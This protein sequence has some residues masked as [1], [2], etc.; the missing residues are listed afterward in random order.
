MSFARIAGTGSYLPEG[1]LTNADLERMVDTSDEWI[2][3]RTGI[4]IRHMAAPG[5]VTSDLALHASR[6]ALEAA[7]LTAAELDL[8]LVATTTPDQIFPSTACLLQ[9][10]LEVGGCPAFDVQAVCSGF[11]YALA[12]A[13]QF[14]RTGQSR[15]VLVVGAETLSRITDY[16]D[17]SNC[18][19]WGDGAGA[20]VLSRSDEPGIISTHLHADGS[21]RSLLEVPGGIS[22]N[23]VED[24]KIRMEGRA[25]FRVAVNT[26]DQ[27]VDETLAHNGIAKSDLDWLVPHQANIRIIQATAKKLAMSM[28][29]V[30]VTVDTHGNTSAA[31]IPLALDVAVRDGRIKPGDLILTEAFGG[32]FTW[33]AALIRM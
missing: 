5:E 33:G 22:R 12:T 6:R 27:I 16:T 31:S 19:L 29:H 9:A 23:D 25:V 13:D 11:V 10:K 32:G 24:T 15:H 1:I 30:V 2:V 18:I 26:L 20:V 21:Q 28:D 14:I 3:D 17:R 7:G 4:R 8:I